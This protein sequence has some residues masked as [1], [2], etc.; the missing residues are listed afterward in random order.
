MLLAARPI[1]IL[2][3]AID[4]VIQTTLDF[5]TGF[6]GHRTRMLLSRDSLGQPRDQDLADLLSLKNFQAD[7]MKFASRLNTRNPERGLGIRLFKNR[8]NQTPDP[9]VFALIFGG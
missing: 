9:G 1:T 4:H 8:T 3:A 5:G 2:I 6:T 7:E